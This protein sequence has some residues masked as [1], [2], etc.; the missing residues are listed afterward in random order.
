MIDER[1]E[2]ILE[3]MREVDAEDSSDAYKI[4]IFEE[5]IRAAEEA[6]DYLK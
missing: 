6:L 5:I 3:L 4:S 1:L 2:Q